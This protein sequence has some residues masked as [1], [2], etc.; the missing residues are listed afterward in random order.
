VSPLAFPAWG[1]DGSVLALSGISWNEKL[2]KEVMG[3]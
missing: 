3:I 2:T 1:P